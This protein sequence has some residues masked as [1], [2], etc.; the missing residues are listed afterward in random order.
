VKKSDANPSLSEAG[1][2][3]CAQSQV[4]ALESEHRRLEAWLPL[5]QG[6][7]MRGSVIWYDSF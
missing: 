3:F 4:G 5:G 7:A 1:E 2:H 6:F